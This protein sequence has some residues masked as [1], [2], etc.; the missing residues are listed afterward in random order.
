M[1]TNYSSF[2]IKNTTEVSII[3]SVSDP[4]GNVLTV[5][6]LRPGIESTQV[7]PISASWSIQRSNPD[8]AQNL[9]SSAPAGPTMITGDP[10]VMEARNEPAPPLTGG[11]TDS[12]SIHYEAFLKIETG[13]HTA[14]V[15]QLLVTPDGKS[16]I[17]SGEDKTI[18]IWDVES[19]K[20]T[21]MLLGQIGEGEE[22]MIQAISM[23]RD[24]KY[25]VALVWM[26]PG[27]TH[28]PQERE[29]D[30]RVY[31]LETGNLQA[32][33]RYPGTLQDFD[34]SPDDNYVA[35][36]GNPNES[37]RRGHVYVHDS[38]KI[39][40][41]FGDL[42][43]PLKED[44]L[45]DNDTLIPSY[46]RF[47]PDDPGEPARYRIVAATWIHNN[48]YPGYDSYP[49]YTG[50]LLWYDYIPQTDMTRVRECETGERIYPL[51]L[52]VSREFVA[53]AGDENKFFCHDH[54][55]NVVATIP[56]ETK[57]GQPTFSKDGNQL[58][59]GQRDDSAVVQVKVYNTSLG[60]FLLASTYYGHDAHTVAVNFLPDGTA[61]SAGGDQ[62][63]IHFWSTAHL[64]GEQIAAIRGMGRV[65][66]AIGVN[67]Q[68]QIGIGN[69][70]DL[71]LEDG[72]IILQRVFDLHAM[73]LK[74]LSFLESATFQRAQ[75]TFGD[76]S[77]EKIGADLYLQPEYWQVRPGDWYDPITFGFTQRGT[78]VAGAH[79]GK[80]R[81]FPQT[82]DGN[83]EYSERFLVG[84]TA[85]LLDHAASSKWLVTAGKDQVI[86]L[87][88]TEDV[89]QDVMTDLVPALNLFVGVDDEWVI[90]S[91]S[92]YYMASQTGDRYLG[93]HINRGSDK[94]ALFFSSD[95]F[96]NVFL[97]PDIIQAILFYGSEE[98]AAEKE[99]ETQISIKSVDVGEILPP[100]IELDQDG[101]NIF[102]SEDTKE[103]FVTFTLTAE[104]HGK[105]ITRLCVLRN[106]RLGHV[107]KSVPSSGKIKIP[108][109]PLLPGENRFKIFAENQD[110]ESHTIKSS[111]IEQT[112]EAKA[113]FD[114]QDIMQNG[115]LYILAIG[116]STA[117]HLKKRIPG[118]TQGYFELSYAHKDAS[119][120]FDAFASANKAFEGVE[121]TLLVNEQATLG[122]IL[123]ALDEIDQKINQ[124]IEDRVTD[125]QKA[126]RDV[127]LVYLSGHG[128]FR[129][130]N[131]QL[132]FWN[133]DFDL[134]RPGDTGLAFM[135]LG[136]KITSLPAEVILMTDACNS[137]MA[138]SDVLKGF[139]PD[140]NGIDP[141]ELAK[142]IYGIN[143][144]DMYIFNAARR[145][146][147]ALEGESVQ[148]MSVEHGYFTKA[149]LDALGES[150]NP[151]MTM[152]GLVDQVQWRVQRF[153]SAQNPVCRMYGDLLPLVI[154]DK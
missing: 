15:N 25:I 102:E 136:E 130:K 16:L 36:V 148:G 73:T 46:V 146:E 68:E 10:V 32:R 80:L 19:K 145:S 54:E 117:T 40:Q 115:T 99:T 135:A 94:E 104:S 48:G 112:I 35:A 152:I 131:Q 42:P 89:D 3:L 50:K 22:G 33:F 59:V 13:S 150:T 45:Y 86:R 149:I 114:E 60:Q 77:L 12:E 109:L 4:D 105:P 30:V 82:A 14:R 116:V 133:Y 75:T 64:E 52:S 153:T 132:Y 96:H 110:A 78:I 106:G 18:R 76:K 139:D 24:G 147:S 31:E 128:V 101:V 118:D 55:G 119:A 23:S 47:V 28:D 90:W 17:T 144:S 65:V 56:S 151:G 154:Y 79:D 53:F 69:R 11:S 29:T 26:Y 5:G 58:I 83:H 103:G 100:I 138:G 38:T 81:V 34:F 95:R 49:E 61:V 98:R 143:E 111:P 62:Y 85:R 67:E 125:G 120:V 9:D 129:I 137:G 44:V 43:D 93:Y 91:K 66:R 88:Y 63:S 7:A 57:P 140:K 2:Q 113:R 122:N 20:Q 71:R 126:K 108:P 41:G 1:P 124:K 21:G 127:L 134:D 37:V 92:G 107:E 8:P 97:R 141:N 123:H 74:S 6:T 84:H 39:L 27:G 51:S 121:K 72:N 142:R 87:W 70:E